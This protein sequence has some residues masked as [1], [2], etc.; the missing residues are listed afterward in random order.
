MQALTHEGLYREHHSWLLGWLD[1]RLGHASD[2]AL[3][4]AQETFLRILQAGEHPPALEKPR[5]YLATIARG[6]LVDHFRRQDLE[7]AYLAELAAL[8]EDVQPSPE[9]RAVMLETILAIDRMLDGLGPRPKQ[10][11]LLSQL[12]GL[13]Y[14]EIAQRLGVSVSSVK[15]YIQKAVLHCLEFV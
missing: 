15:K 5:P 2:R 3:D 7:R 6:L 8:P 1:Y 4:F 13:G 10:A 12:E 11:F 14:A 9:E